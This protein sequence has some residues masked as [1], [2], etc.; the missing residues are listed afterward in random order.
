M[1]FH[2]VCGIIIEM[3][4]AS[5]FRSRGG[6]FYERLHVKRRIPRQNVARKDE[7]QAL[8]NSQVRLVR[9]KKFDGHHQ[10]ERAG[11]THEH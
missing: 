4:P 10:L 6:D 9:R 8:Q 2:N 3:H 7:G 11:E 1:T 5:I